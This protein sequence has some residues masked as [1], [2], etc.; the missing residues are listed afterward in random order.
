MITKEEIKANYPSIKI[1]VNNETFEISSGDDYDNYIN[2]LFEAELLK[3]KQQEIEAEKLTAKEAAQA[4]LA[5]L[6]LT[7]EDLEALGL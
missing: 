2:I 3:E 1:G 5:A 6:G 7:T 4:K